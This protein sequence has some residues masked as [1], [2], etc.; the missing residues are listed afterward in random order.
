MPTCRACSTR[1]D[2][3]FSRRIKWCYE[4]EAK[5]KAKVLAHMEEELKTLADTTGAYMAI[6]FEDPT[7]AERWGQL[8]DVYFNV[9]HT[10]APS[11]KATKLRAFEIRLN[12]TIAKGGIFGQLCEAWW[13]QQCRKYDYDELE[14]EIIKWGG[15]GE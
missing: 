15:E 7:L 10:I 9:Q 4:C 5:G 11:L 1:Y 13:K 14:W 12:R 2:C 3:D 6:V 8:V